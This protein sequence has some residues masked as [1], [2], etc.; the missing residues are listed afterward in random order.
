MKTSTFFNRIILL[1]LL[2]LFIVQSKADI[3]Y[4]EFKSINSGINALETTL[5]SNKITIETWLYVDNN[6]G[7]I[8]SNM[9]EDKGFLLGFDGWFK[10]QLDGSSVWID[11]S[12]W[13]GKWTH[14]ACVADGSNMIV[15][16]NGQS[17]GS[18]ASPGYNVEAD[19][20]PLFVGR[21]PWGSPMNGKVAD[22]RLWNVARTAAEIQNNYKKQ[23]PAD[24]EGLIKNFYFNEGLG[25]STADIINPEGNRGW[26]MGTLGT[27]YAWGLV[28]KT[29]VNL[30]YEKVSENEL[31]LIWEGSA[32]LNNQWTVEVTNPDN[33]VVL[34]ENLTQE[35]VHVENMIAGRYEFRVKEISFMETEL[36]ECMEVT[37]PIITGINDT[38]AEN[39]EGVLR[40]QNHRVIISN[41]YASE[42]LLHVYNTMGQL[43]LSKAF[44]NNQIEIDMS[45]WYQD[46]YV[47][48]LNN[49][50][51]S[52]TW[53]IVR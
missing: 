16:A 49:N 51:M 10:F 20:K 7:F 3:G 43:I 12:S 14:I 32:V 33:E 50:G 36:S 8:T 23:I 38:K 2:N 48:K 47:F 35:T 19:N 26:F 1:S 44:E 25:D 22:F 42:S 31:N 27:D 4:A 13:L 18:S 30:K 24:T 11:P 6:T 46:I 52:K 17:V 53:K 39:F 37:V 9:H 28:A 45:D 41:S 15:Y 29:P 34:L 40:Q 21:A 5:G